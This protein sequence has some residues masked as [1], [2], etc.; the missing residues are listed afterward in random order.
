MQVDIFVY[1]QASGSREGNYTINKLDF[2]QGNENIQRM[3]LEFNTF[4]ALKT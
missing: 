3:N 1:F 2:R 4:V